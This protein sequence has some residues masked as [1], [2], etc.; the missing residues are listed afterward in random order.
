[1]LPDSPRSLQNR[2]SPAKLNVT[3][4][5]NGRRD[6]GFHRL[7]SIVAQTEFGDRMD[8]KWTPAGDASEDHVSFMQADL[9]P[10]D[11]TVVA[12]M[13]AFRS[14][15]GLEHGCFSVRVTKHIPSGA[16]LGGGSSNATTFIQ[17][18]SELF[19]ELKLPLD[20]TSALA[21][22]GSDCPL[23]LSGSPVLMEGRGECI[24]PL[25]APLADR[26]QGQEVVIFKP[27]FGIQTAAAF[28]RLAAIKVYSPHTTAAEMIRS[29][30][31][32]DAVLPVPLNDF[33]RILPCWLPS[34]DLVLQRLRA[35]GL[36]ARLSGSGSAV[37]VAGTE[38]KCRV[39][40]LFA[41]L[42]HAWGNCYW[43][44]VTR[45]K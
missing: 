13:R 40:G 18:A 16:G 4:A 6:D 42:Q 2:L 1:M 12:A 28:R 43:Y 34:L 14:T 38:Y 27:T 15:T 23:F 30:S 21:A 41:E 36:D 7:T 29:W 10:E 45:L 11:N 25:P 17:A 37:F 33:E 5:V 44:R 9:P 22:I 3:L 26:L 35:C 24:Q 39:A 20:W 8:I 32:T 31:D 19:P